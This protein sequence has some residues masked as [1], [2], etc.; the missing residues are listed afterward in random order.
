MSRIQVLLASFGALFW[1][2]AC[3]QPAPPRR[4]PDFEAVVVDVAPDGDGQL[5]LLVNTAPP[6]A[7]VQAVI[8]LASGAASLEQQ[9][10]GGF[11]RRRP[12]PEWRGRMVRIWFTHR[13]VVEAGQAFSADAEAILVEPPRSA[14][15]L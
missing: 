11:V 12:T 10:D 14:V 5:R 7:P 15:G 9:P 13:F 1:M 8:R 3:T 4:G 2:A 6:D